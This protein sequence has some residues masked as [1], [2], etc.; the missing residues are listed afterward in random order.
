MPTVDLETLAADTRY[1][2]ESAAPST[3]AA[4]T[5]VTYVGTDGALHVIDDAGTDTALGASTGYDLAGSKKDGAATAMPIIPGACVYSVSASATNTGMIFYAP[6]MLFGPLPV[7][8]IGMWFTT[9]D[10]TNKARI[11]L[12]E[13]DADWQPTDLVVEGEVNPSTTG[14]KLV[15][16]GSTL[17]AGKYL[18]A[19]LGNTSAQHR[20]WLAYSQWI[21][22]G[23]G[24]VSQFRKTRT[25]GTLPST[26]DVWNDVQDNGTGMVHRVYLYPNL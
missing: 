25:Y 19:Y 11:G 1:W 26:G 4:G 3:P 10:A 5:A 6:I 23:A 16:V 22:T 18:T 2:A 14:E 24:W 17:P 9:T 15:A 8:N 7:A 13:A 12:Y 21:D 20:K